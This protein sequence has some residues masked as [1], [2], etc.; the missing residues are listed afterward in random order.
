MRDVEDGRKGRGLISRQKMSLKART[1][2]WMGGGESLLRDP[3]SQLR[4]TIG[5]REKR[6]A[7]IV[8]G[9]GNN[10]H[11]PDGLYFE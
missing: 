10:I 2:V 4:Q 1:V 11:F 5:R 3:G 9:I 7:E 8:G 6:R